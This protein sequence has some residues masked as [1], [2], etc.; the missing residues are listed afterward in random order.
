MK[1]KV[2]LRLVTGDENLVTKDEYYVTF[3]ENGTITALK[4]RNDSGELAV[5]LDQHVD[6]YVLE[7]N[8]TKSVNLSTLSNGGTITVTP[9]SGND[10][11]K[12]VTVTVVKDN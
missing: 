10:G 3:D 6:Q 11:M 9:T 1:A 2:N 5:V 4:K 12:K 7:D 8:K